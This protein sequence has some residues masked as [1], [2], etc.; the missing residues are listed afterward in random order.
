MHVAD[1]KL[2]EL[3]SHDLEVDAPC[4]VAPNSCRQGRV[5]ENN[6]TA[7]TV[8]MKGNS[9]GASNF[10]LVRN[11]RYFPIDRSENDYIPAF[12]FVEKYA[13]WMR[14]YRHSLGIDD[15]ENLSGCLE[16]RVQELRGRGVTSADLVQEVLEES[17]FLP[18]NIAYHHCE[19]LS[20]ANFRDDKD[21]KDQPGAMVAQQNPRASEDSSMCGCCCSKFHCMQ[22]PVL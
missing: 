15:T 22:R 14:E 9:Y 10:C 20:S 5:G 12:G 21:G 4:V 11:T 17:T 16:K 19:A 8:T 1:P 7:R 6:I 13:A 2:Q 3:G 18:Y